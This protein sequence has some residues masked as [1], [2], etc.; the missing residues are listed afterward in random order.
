M[1]EEQ[2]QAGRRR[3]QR[4]PWDGGL[5]AAELER[6][7]PVVRAQVLAA[8]RNARDEELR[9]CSDLGVADPF[10]RAW[11]EWNSLLEGSDEPE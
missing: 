10:S 1:S 11:I 6:L 2:R 8:R 5:S 7:D 4:K 9:D 3:V